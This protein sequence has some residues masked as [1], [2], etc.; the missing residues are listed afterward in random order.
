M[1]CLRTSVSPSTSRLRTLGRLPDGMD[2][3]EHISPSISPAPSEPSRPPGPTEVATESTA[4]V[5]VRTKVDPF[6]LPFKPAVEQ[7]V[8]E[9]E[10]S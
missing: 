3:E 2:D 9:F 1:L 6:P 4:S 8:Q 5:A 7:M 10:P